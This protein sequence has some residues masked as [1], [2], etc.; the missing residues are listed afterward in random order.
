MKSFE[1]P[2]NQWSYSISEKQ[3]LSRIREYNRQKEHRKANVVCYTTAFDINTDLI[4]PELIINDW[5]YVV[6]SNKIISGEH[7]FKNINSKVNQTNPKLT[8]YY[9]KTHPHVLFP[10]Y[11]YSIWLDPNILVRGWHLKK[12]VDRCMLENIHF[13]LNPHPAHSTMK[14]RLI[15]SRKSPKGP[16]NVIERQIRRYLMEGLPETAM[17][18]ETNIIIR[19]HLNTKVIE[20]NKDWWNEIV[21]GIKGDRLSLPFVLWKHNI[22]AGLI[23]S[24]DNPKKED[25]YSFFQHNLYHKQNAK[26]YKRPG[27]IRTYTASNEVLRKMGVLK[28]FGDVG[29]VSNIVAMRQKLQKFGFIYRA[30][31]ELVQFTKSDD[32]GFF[33]QEAA[34]VLA[35]WHANKQSVQQ[36]VNC[37]QFAN[38][39][40]STGMNINRAQRAAV[41]KAECYKTLGE[42][43][44]AEEAISNAML[45]GPSADLLIAKMNI[46]NNA[47]SKIKW[48]NK[49]YEQFK[50]L[51]VRLSEDQDPKVLKRL[52]GGDV[53]ACSKAKTSIKTLVS[54]IVPVFNAEDTIKWALD[55]LLNQT[56]EDI[57]IIVADDCSNDKTTSI[58]KEYL[59]RDQR[60]KLICLPFNQGPYVARNY[61]LK[62]AKGEFVTC[63]DADDWSHP[64]KIEIQAAHLLKNKDVIANT[65]ELIR[66]TD[67]LN[68]FIRGNA[69]YYLHTN[70]SS[71]MFRRKKLMKSLG[72]WDSVRFGADS[73]L[74]FRIKKTFGPYSVEHLKTGPLMLALQSEKSLTSDSKYGIHGFIMGARAEYR[75]SF[76]NY[77]N[78]SNDLFYGFPMSKRK[79]SIPEPM[80]PSLNDE[81]N[82][83]RHFDQVIAFDFRLEGEIINTIIK[84]ISKNVRNGV[85]TALVQLQ[86]YD[87]SINDHPRINSDIRKCMDNEN[88][89]MIVY[90]E[91]I[92]CDFLI[93]KHPAVLMD[94]QKYVPEIDAREIII[95]EGV[96]TDYTYEKNCFFYER[97]TCNN[98]LQRYFHKKGKWISDEKLEKN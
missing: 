30:Y 9:L 18:Y 90:G 16:N 47:E 70:Y 14:Q 63:A 24:E 1:K 42:M 55:S 41:L 5:D 31:Q 37:L 12:T 15:A 93:V 72:Y 60:I 32:S 68:P 43:P 4:I 77:L 80:K 27:F 67:D 65:S 54:V 29:G 75:D 7:I 35:N 97:V 21:S 36:A 83:I 91:Q 86:I 59:K 56:W 46:E 25:D 45:L 89:Q 23:N 66:V 64:E 48:L 74:L 73:E 81:M 88:I 84:E 58:V 69:G 39:A 96:N 11:K 57:E 49:A 13:M 62:E 95:E 76:L 82:N 51:P 94:F 71:L 52:R 87:L 22:S 2:V 10:Q 61:A 44:K 85:R 28:S 26:Q 17:F 34:W 19:H 33:K 40:T 6:F 79:F 38:L 98:N 3:L 78:N 53:E 8:T 92:T 50:V 20:A